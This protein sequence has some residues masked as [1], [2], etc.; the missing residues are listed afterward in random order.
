MAKSAYVGIDNKARKVKY[1]Y[2][3][4]DGKARK[5]KKGYIGVGGVAKLFYKLS[6]K[7]EKTLSLSAARRWP[8]AAGNDNY[9]IFAGGN[10]NGVYSSGSTLGISNVVDIYDNNLVRTTNTLGVKTSEAAGAALGNTSILFAGGCS[11]YPVIGSSTEQGDSKY[12]GP[13]SV[14][15]FN[16]STLAKTSKSLTTG[17]YFP[18]AA[19]NTTY[20][21]V[22]GGQYAT[23]EYTT[24]KYETTWHD[25]STAYSFNASGTRSTV[26]T[27]G[28]GELMSASTDSYAFF[29]SADN[30]ISNLYGIN[31]SGTRK[32]ATIP[33][34]KYQAKGKN[35]CVG[36]AT[37]MYIGGGYSS[38]TKTTTSMQVYNSSLVVSTA[39]NLDNALNNIGV[40][41]GGCAGFVNTAT[42]TV[43]VYD[44]V[45]FVKTYADSLTKTTYGFD[46]CASKNLGFIGGGYNGASSSSSRVVY[47]DVL[48]YNM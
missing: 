31:T 17:T 9:A 8:S 23:R 45:T 1:I 2:V 26:S 6:G 34:G 30:T 25:L 37:H 42:K 27:V 21:I 19:S 3:G 36:N 24:H 33:T 46:S 4:V 18:A 38:S 47:S 13:T 7:V 15:I 11:S 22:A 20:I 43:E 32:T 12:Y 28:G 5:V 48:V 39:A 14:T 44:P 10:R 29:Y 16:G 35:A 40:N 41:L